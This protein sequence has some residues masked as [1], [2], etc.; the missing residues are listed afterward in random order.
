MDQVAQPAVITAV[1]DGSLKGGIGAL[2]EQAPRFTLTLILTAIGLYVNSACREV[3]GFSANGAVRPLQR[4]KREQTCLTNG[5][6][7]NS[8]EWRT[9]DTAIGGE[10]SEE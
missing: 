3:Q 5:K 8:K 2:T 9:T 1:G 6:S 4:S 7:G 10:K